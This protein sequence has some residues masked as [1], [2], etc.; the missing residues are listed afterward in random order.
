ML[1]SGGHHPTAVPDAFLDTIPEDQS[2][3]QQRVS[4]LSAASAVASSD[5]DDEEDENNPQRR[6]QRRQN[7]N[8]SSTKQ[9]SNNNHNNNHHHI[10]SR[11]GLRSPGSVASSNNAIIESG[12]DETSSSAQ[13]KKPSGASPRH[14]CG[15]GRSVTFYILLSVMLVGISIGVYFIVTR[16]GPSSTSSSEEDPL[17]SNG[18]TAASS[19][20]PTP[21][22][23]FP[24]NFYIDMETDPPSFAPS[25]NLNDMADIDETLLKITSPADYFDELTP[26]GTCR[27]WLTR[28][29]QLQ[30]T[31]A[32]YGEEAVQQRY[33]LCVLYH[34]TNGPT[35]WLDA[36]LP[37]LDEELHE[38]D[39][40]GISCEESESVAILYLSERNLQGRI[41]SELIH[42]SHLQLLSLGENKLTGTIPQGLLELPRLI[43]IDLSS[44]SLTG[45]IPSTATSPTTLS[46]YSPLEVLYLDGNLLEGTVPFF[47]TLERM[48]VQRNL[49]TGFDPGY[50]SLQSLT[51]WKMYDNAISGPLP[52]IWNAPDLFYVDL[53]LNQWTGA[54]PESLWNLPSL[55]SLVLHDA[56]LTGTLPESTVSDH[57][58][59][60]W[61][62]SN[63]LTG[64]IPPTFGSDWANVTELL[65]HNN[66]FTG[67]ILTA[68]CDQWPYLNRLETDCNRADLICTCCTVCHG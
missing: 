49:F 65:L 31:V 2:V 11:R 30:V 59:Y 6:Q 21:E 57:W 58:E 29:D 34:A 28:Y 33:I 64:T 61:I 38:C 19:G 39:W 20:S 10:S 37:F 4:N 7:K 46:R 50:A 5:S 25:M 22:L 8:K 3:A 16:T 47:D 23:T 41:P 60:L 40:E 18:G 45:N 15:K 48:R 52:E 68:Q 44:N 62:H 53:A 26:Q 51:S 12:L 43:Y 56:A 14:L 67:T 63:L 17:P 36:A 1:L 55:K 32:S 13:Q 24:P 54:I 42:L 9:S 27:Y 35:E 66:S